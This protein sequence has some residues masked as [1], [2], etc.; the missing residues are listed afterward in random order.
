MHVDDWKE[1]FEEVGYDY[2]YFGSYLNLMNK[3]FDLQK[4]IFGILKDYLNME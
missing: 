2:D 3:L 1:V 4:L